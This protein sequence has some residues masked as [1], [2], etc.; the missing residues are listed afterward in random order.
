MTWAWAPHSGRTHF[1]HPPPR[2]V[3]AHETRTKACPR[4]ACGGT[5]IASH[6]MP[7]HMSYWARRYVHKLR[8]CDHT[9]LAAHS[10]PCHAHVCP[11][12]STNFEC[13]NMRMESHVSG[14]LRVSTDCCGQSDIILG[15]HYRPRNWTAIH[16]HGCPMIVSLGR[17]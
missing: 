16:N 9:K 5:K 13:P 17:P 11:R 3:G 6:W 8:P 4:N 12:L 14:N 1:T 2:V 7:M 10:Y 15:N